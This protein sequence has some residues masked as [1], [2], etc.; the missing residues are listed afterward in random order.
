[1]K[2]LR[3][4]QALV[5]ALLTL[6]AIL[7]A[8]Q[9]AL[10]RNT[11]PSPDSLAYFEV[12]DQITKSGYG[13]AL[14]T[15]WSPLYPLYLIAAR[16]LT[17]GA[18]ASELTVTAAADVFALLVLCL[19]VALAFRSIA[20]LCWPA[21]AT[22][23]H[24]WT[25]YVVGLAV[26]LA[27]CV[28]R[29]GLRLPDALV[30]ICAVL[31]LWAWCKACSS[32]LDLR[33][34]AVAGGAAGV[35]FL[36]RGNL[37]HWSVL[38][39]VIAAAVAPGVSRRRRIAALGAFA[40][41]VLA[42]FGPHTYAM[43]AAQGRFT[44]GESGRLAFAVAYGAEYPNGQAWPV[45]HAGGDVRTFPEPRVVAYPGFYDPSREFADARIQFS[46]AALARSAL[47]AAAWC[48]VGNQTGAFA[49][50]WPMLWGAWPVAVLGWRRPDPSR[51][52]VR[53]GAL[54]TLAGLGGIAMHLLSVC[55]G[56]YLPPYVIALASGATLM[57]VETATAD[58]ATAIR[59]LRVAGI[60]FAAA[61]AV[62]TARYVR[63]SEA[64]ARHARVM[65]TDALAQ[66]LDA[67]PPDEAGVSRVAVAGYWLGLYAVRLSGSQV[68]ADLPD[69]AILLDAQRRERAL[70]TLRQL[71]VAAL[72][73]PADSPAAA[74]VPNAARIPNTSWMLVD[75]A[76]PQT[77]DENSGS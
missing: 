18:V 7:A 39:A 3:L 63:T 4:S 53:L 51:L 65:E 76:H 36:A 9:F 54:L 31:M 62:L 25:A 43:S 22:P 49:L 60:G 12:A 10:L 77:P 16:T 66:A 52:G 47:R 48:S 24:A 73:L 33:W 67:H 1:V 11:M 55:N 42:V 2:R 57:V 26:Y 68:T 44:F 35:A 8:A 64:T 61:A 40:M 37:L 15:H 58:R 72:L 75:I 27:F 14:P 56:Y 41:V 30:T 59:A 20:R 71:D 45:Q 13:T 70:T 50:L 74:A 32:G 29:V 6:A 17:S 38:V 69:P 21:D 34:V 23:R 19:T 5:L 46:V 28:L